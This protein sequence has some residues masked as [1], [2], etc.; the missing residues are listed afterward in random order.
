[1]NFEEISSPIY[2]AGTVV[3]LDPELVEYPTGFGH[4]G[5]K[6]GSR[7]E[8][9]GVPVDTIINPFEPL[10]RLLPKAAAAVMWEVERRKAFLIAAAIEKRLSSRCVS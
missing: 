2:L 5:L 3:V 6:A 8:K 1:M 10:T 7:L 9:N 4:D